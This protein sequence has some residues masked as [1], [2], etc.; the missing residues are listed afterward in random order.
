MRTMAQVITLA[1]GYRSTPNEPHV[2]IVGQKDDD[3][4][5]YMVSEPT[6]HAD[7]LAQMKHGQQLWSDDDE[8]TVFMRAAADPDV[9][10]YR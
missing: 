2:Y 1:S 6:T 10:K 3:G 8:K 7:A 9:D 5:H 4:W